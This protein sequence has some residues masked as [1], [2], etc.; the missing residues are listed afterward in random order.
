MHVRTMKKRLKRSLKAVSLRVLGHP[1]DEPVEKQ[2]EALNRKLRVTTKDHGW[3]R[4]FRV[5]GGSIRWFI[6]PGRSG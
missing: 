3:R 4:I 6:R 5:Y 2:C 1:P